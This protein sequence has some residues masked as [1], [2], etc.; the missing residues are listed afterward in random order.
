M[1]AMAQSGS[2]DFQAQQSPP[3]SGTGRYNQAALQ[4]LTWQIQVAGAAWQGGF[5]LFL[6]SQ[7]H[8]LLVA[9]RHAGVLRG[10][11]G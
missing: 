1:L 3:P 10:Q 7:A 9:I 5:L 11:L 8:R 4:R 6:A 2:Y